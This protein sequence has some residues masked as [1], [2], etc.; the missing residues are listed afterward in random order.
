MVTESVISKIRIQAWMFA[1]IVSIKWGSCSGKRNKTFHFLPNRLLLNYRHKNKN[2]GFSGKQ[3]HTIKP[4]QEPFYF[5][6][7][8]RGSDL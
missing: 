8:A 3:K 5:L 6:A 4:R 2:I 1:K 7:T